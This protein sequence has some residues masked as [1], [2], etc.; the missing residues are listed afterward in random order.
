MGPHT[1]DSKSLL[2]PLVVRVSIRVGL[3][4][5]RLRAQIFQKLVIE[6]CPP[7]HRSLLIPWAAISILPTLEPTVYKYDLFWAIWSPWDLE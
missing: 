3:A 2:G 5:I 4:V 7:S 1:Q 6:E